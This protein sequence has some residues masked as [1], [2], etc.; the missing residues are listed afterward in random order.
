VQ[1]NQVQPDM[2]L[3]ETIT[4]VLETGL[5]PMAVERKLLNLLD[6][7]EMSEA[8]IVL[9]D[10]LIEALAQGEVQATA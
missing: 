4:Q 6:S 9:I 1:E 5:L 3:I 8:E 10:R 7:K 2:Q